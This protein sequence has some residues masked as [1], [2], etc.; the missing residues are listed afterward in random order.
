M[1]SRAAA[2]VIIFVALAIVPPAAMVLDEP[3]YIDIGTRI[4]IFA[5][6]ALSLDL[7]LGY[8][9]MVSF[10][11]ATYLGIGAYAVGILAYFGVNNGFVQFTTAIISSALAALFIGAVSVRT[12]GVYFIMITLAFGQMLY[13][14]A[15]SI[16][17]FG[18][19]DGMTIATTSDFAGLLDLHKPVILYYTGFA[20]LFAFA[21]FTN[22]LVGSRFGMV[23]RAMNLNE[24]RAG[25]IGVASFRY[26]LV[27]FAISGAMCGVG[28]ALLA[29]QALFVSP[30]IMHWTR[31]GEIM[32][33]VILGGIG[34]LFG[35][36]I[37]A[38]AY[39]ILEDFLSRITEHWQVILGPILIAVV[40][41][42]HRGIFGWLVAQRGKFAGGRNAAGG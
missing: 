7:I 29:N 20:V 36:I 16:R 12:A 38:V 27:A 25:A 18:G 30:A 6:A 2:A 21:V 22:R 17:T 9:G 11:H 8:G 19:D 1:L 14:L 42:A 5:I 34:T 23:I 39:L 40:L 32:V 35:P 24:Q 26:K 41:F 4:I 33:M 13:F 10:G 37:G 15:I 3:F 28:G 31:S